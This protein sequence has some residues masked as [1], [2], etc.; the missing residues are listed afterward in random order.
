[1]ASA[2]SRIGGTWPV[3]AKSSIAAGTL[4]PARDRPAGGRILNLEQ[5]QVA[6]DLPVAHPVMP[7]LE[8]L[9]LDAHEV[10]HVVLATGVAQR[11]AQHVALLELACG[12]QQ[13]AG[14]Q[15]HT[16]L[17]ALGLGQLVE[18]QLRGGLARIELALEAVEPRG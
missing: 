10:V 6:V 2:T 1:M 7:F 12:V 17:G 3:N 11:P 16:E 8:L 9:L 14:Q 4:P 15:L 13:V 5:L 18:V